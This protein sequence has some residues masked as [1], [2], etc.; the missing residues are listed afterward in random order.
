M[1]PLDFAVVIEV[2]RDCV[3]DGL[4]DMANAA[5]TSTVPASLM[6]PLGALF[7]SPPPST[8]RPM[9]SGTDHWAASV[10]RPRTTLNAAHGRRPARCRDGPR[11][12]HLL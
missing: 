2:E 8:M 10:V 12:S 6:W 11:R 9:K 5:A 4:D 3:L 1:D 7:G